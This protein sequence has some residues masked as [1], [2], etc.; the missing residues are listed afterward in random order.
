MKLSSA[1]GRIL[2]M[3]ET[4]AAFESRA[5]LAKHKSL[6]LYSPSAFVIAQSI[7]DLPMYFIP[8][9]LYA[10]V[11]WFLS[12]MKMQAGPFFIF[13]LFTYTNTCTFAAFF[14]M[15]GSAFPTFEDA[16]KISGFFFNLFATYCTSS[17]VYFSPSAA[18]IASL[19]SPAGYFIY[20]R[21][22]KDYLGWTRYVEADIY[23]FYGL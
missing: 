18:D 1:N 21:D 15:V 13:L 14:R 4:T 2:T 16:S 10:I 22:M 23:R 7:A 3:A 19:Y 5:I 6:S 9:S 20:I 11:L 12:G 17:T 8:L